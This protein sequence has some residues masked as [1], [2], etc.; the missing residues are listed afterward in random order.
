M[1]LSRAIDIELDR[2]HADG[3]DLDCGI[4]KVRTAQ[5]FLNEGSLL[6]TPKSLWKSLW[7]EGE[8]CCLFSDANLGK[9]ALAVQI[10][11]HISK[12]QRVCFVDCE[13]SCKQFEL[14]YCNEQGMHYVFSPNFLR[15]E[16]DVSQMLVEDN[17]SESFEARIIQSLEEITLRTNSKVLIVD[18]LTFLCNKSEAGDSAGLLMLQL[19]RLKRKYKLSLLIIAHTPKRNMFNPLTANDLAGSRKLFNFFDSVFGLGRSARDENLRYVKQLKCRFGAFE[20]G[21][22]HVILCELK[23]I[24]SFLKFVEIGYCHENEHLRQQSQSDREALRQ[25][26]IN[27][28]QQ[29]LSIR[30]IAE[31]L[32]VSKSLIGKLCKSFEGNSIPVEEMPF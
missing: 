23:K 13:L 14:R 22:D 26:V 31:R 5:D 29:N 18:N 30:T 7:Y 2:F 12:S 25:S 17:G 6:E 20:Y 3:T 32:G 27:L 19:L 4:F 24:D 9:S 8:C 10:G 21:S 16:L 15:A 1:D 11:D 28:R